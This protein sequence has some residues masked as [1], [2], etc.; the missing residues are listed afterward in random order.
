MRKTQQ[1]PHSAENIPKIDPALGGRPPVRYEAVRQRLGRV[2][3]FATQKGASVHMPRI[4]CGLAGGKW[5][6]I[7]PILEETLVAANLQVTVYDF[8]AT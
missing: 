6:E 1:N 8:S 3:E 5:E 7:E 2:A 4:G